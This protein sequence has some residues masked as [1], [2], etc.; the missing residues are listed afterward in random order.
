M[1]LK[2]A[3]IVTTC[4][5]AKLCDRAVLSV[6]SQTRIPDR[7]VVVDDGHDAWP[8][9]YEGVTCVRTSGRIGSAAARNLGA[10]SVRDCDVLMFLDDDDTWDANKVRQ[11]V[12]GFEKYEDAVLVYTGRI[13]VSDPDD[14][15]L[16]TIPAWRSG[17]LERELLIDN[18]IGVTSGVAISSSAFWR[19]GGFDTE[20]PARQDYDLWIRLAPMGRIVADKGYGL[21][22]RLAAPNAENISRGRIDKHLYAIRRLQTKYQRNYKDLSLVERRKARANQTFYIAKIARAR[23]W[24]SGS[25]WALRAFSLFPLPQFVALIFPSTVVTW[26]RQ[27]V[28]W[29]R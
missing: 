6:L 2:V 27:Q 11:Q 24:W 17:F 8:N 25:I 29:R 21:R 22:Y 26:V 18:F 16:Y 10:S 15:V 13:V 12:G 9:S 4:D 20:Q 7:V 19:A 1:V 3:A 14:K 5:R 28:A 23:S